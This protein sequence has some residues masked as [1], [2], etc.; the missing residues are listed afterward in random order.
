MA[1]PKISSR[2]SGPH[3]NLRTRLDNPQQHSDTEST[4]NGVLECLRV[5]RPQGGL[6]GA[7]G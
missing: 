1:E 2:L 6:V 3:I 5:A 4:S 7:T